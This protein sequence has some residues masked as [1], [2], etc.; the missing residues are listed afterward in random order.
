MY[1]SV[2]RRLKT[3]EYG[4]IRDASE[5]ADVKL[6]RVLRNP[7]PRPG[8]I[9]PSSLPRSH[10]GAVSLYSN[11]RALSTC[12]CRTLDS[13]LLSGR[14]E[15]IRLLTYARGRAWSC[16]GFRTRNH[17]V[18]SRPVLRPAI[19]GYILEVEDVTEKRISRRRLAERCCCGKT[20][21]PSPPV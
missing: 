5:E 18:L 1:T 8:R 21:S 14:N 12:S 3:H 19:L 10:H 13:V 6:V 2:G 17:L 15:T 7:A 9:W 16:I 4:G 11:S 20:G